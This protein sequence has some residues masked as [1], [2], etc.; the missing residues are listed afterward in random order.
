MDYI[1]AIDTGGPAFPI[2]NAQYTEAYGGAPG[3]DLRDWFAGQIMASLIS[4]PDNNA[5]M[6][7]LARISYQA[8][9]AMMVARKAGA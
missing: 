3:M 2:Q 9:D 8:S 1:K 7:V 5:E 6:P 4:R